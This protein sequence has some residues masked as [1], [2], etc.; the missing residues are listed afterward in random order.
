MRGEYKVHSGDAKVYVQ[1]SEQVRNKTKITFT[2]H[3]SQHH[4]D[5]S[6]LSWLINI[7]DPNG[8]LARWAISEIRRVRIHCNVDAISRPVVAA[9]LVVVKD[10][11]VK[12]EGVAV[13][14]RS[15]VLA[16]ETR[17]HPIPLLE[18][19]R[20]CVLMSISIAL[21]VALALRVV[22]SRILVDICRSI[23]GRNWEDDT[24]LHLIGIVADSVSSQFW[25][26]V[27]LDSSSRIRATQLPSCCQLSWPCITLPRLATNR[28]HMPFACG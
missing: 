7:R 25:R 5:H 17:E 14:R 19:I 12:I 8:R 27:S 6:A 18:R 16:Q 9:N 10:D 1:K 26:E 23:D 2:Q 28:S 13:D 3:H 15:L 21:D 22:R 24:S 20:T 11:S 4:T